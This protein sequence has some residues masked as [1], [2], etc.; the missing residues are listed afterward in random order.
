[1]SISC[2]C[3]YDD[4]TWHYTAPEDFSTLKT[5]RFRKCCSC[6]CRL[7]PGDTVAEF[8]RDRPPSSEVEERIYGDEVPMAPWFMCEECGGLF[9]ALAEQ[10][11]CIALSKGENMRSL[12]AAARGEA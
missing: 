7:E 8:E 11:Y 1:M 10:G 12:V 4:F 3:D 5:K 9:M 6:G 2:G